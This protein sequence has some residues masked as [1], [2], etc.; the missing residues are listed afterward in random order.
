MR[1][2]DL[3][4]K[5]YGWLTVIA[6]DTD[7]PTKTRKTMWRCQCRCGAEKS[8]YGESLKKGHTSSCGCQ[9]P[10]LVR[11]ARTSHGMSHTPTHR[12][13]QSMKR[14]CSSPTV[15]QYPYYGGRGIRVCER[16]ASFENF[17]EDMGERP[18]GTTLDRIDNDGDYGPSNCC[19]ATPREQGSHTTRTRYVKTERGTVTLAEAARM[20][21]VSSSAILYRIRQGWS[22]A[23]ILAPAQPWAKYQPSTT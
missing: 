6:R 22:E 13:W 15:W 23:D 4:G 10:A 17:L 11:A 8:V 9:R 21:N 1:L 16:W 5:K 20:A 3:T 19:W 2:M 18:A 14:R 7:Y 12:T